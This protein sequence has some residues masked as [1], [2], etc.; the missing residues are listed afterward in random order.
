MRAIKR[1]QTAH[2]GH[3]LTWPDHADLVVWLS[4]QQETTA[5]EAHRAVLTTLRDRVV[6][7]GG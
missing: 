7:L 1:W 2:P 5:A 6:G 3:E 4:G